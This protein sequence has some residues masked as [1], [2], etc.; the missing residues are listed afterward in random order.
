M[1]AA[2]ILIAAVYGWAAPCKGM[3]ETA[4]G[5]EIHMACHYL[6]VPSLVMAFM[7]AAISIEGLRAKKLPSLLLIVSGILTVWMTVGG[8]GGLKICAAPDMS[9]HATVWW[10]RGLGILAVSAGLISLYDPEKQV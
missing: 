3:L 6:K 9:C 4:D 7:W 1:A 5:R 8:M 10:I 2:A